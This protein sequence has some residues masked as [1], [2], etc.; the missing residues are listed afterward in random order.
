MGR[1]SI[2]KRMQVLTAWG[3]S[4]NCVCNL[5]LQTLNVSR[6]S[7]RLKRVDCLVLVGDS[8]NP[9]AKEARDWIEDWLAAKPGRTVI[10]FGRDFTADAYIYEKTLSQQPA[11][12][13]SRASFDLA[14]AQSNLDDKFYSEVKDDVFC[15]WFVLRASKPARVIKQFAGPLSEVMGDGAE[16]PVRSYLDV[17]DNE[18]RDQPPT[19][20]S[21]LMTPAV[22]FPGLRGRNKKPAK[23]KPT[24]FTSYCVLYR[25]QR[26]RN[27][28][29]GMGQNQ[30]LSCAAGW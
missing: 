13:V 14:H 3:S 7:P 12:K 29:T 5:A 22:P 15:R 24:V 8:Y 1:L 23:E 4:K 20:R 19:W 2:Q 28:G 9:P 17:V 10:Y 30:R 27:L 11:E 18:L 6:L 26:R 16:W 21:T 25:H